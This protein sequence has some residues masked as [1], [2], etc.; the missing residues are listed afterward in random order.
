LSEILQALYEGD[1]AR[2]AVL[3]AE[4]PELDLFEAAA[5]GRTER[6]AQL[7]D[8]DRARAQAWAEDGFTAL[9]LAAFF[10][11]PDT[12]R[13]LVEH[14]ARVDAVARNEMSVQPLHS[15]VAARQEETSALLLDRGADANARQRGGFTP[16]HG[17]AQH[18]DDVLVELLLRHGADP[19]LATDDGRAAADFARAGGHDALAE[20]LAS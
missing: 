20:R 17:A 5:L 10:R 18:G 2:V 7:V 11:H 13:L 15:A 6:V 19:G 16:L 4:D 1:E 14:G 8:E 12:A 3:L 9:H